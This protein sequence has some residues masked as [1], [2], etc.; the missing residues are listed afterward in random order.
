MRFGL[1]FGAGLPLAIEA[2]CYYNA[3]EQSSYLLQIWGGF[4][5]VI[6]AFVLFDLDCYVWEKTRVNYMLIFEFNQ[7][8]SLNWRQHLEIVGAVFFIFSLF[9]FLCM[10]NFFPGFTIYFP[11]L[12]L[13]VVGTFLIAPVIVPYWRMRRY[14]IIQLI[15][16]FLSGLSTVHFQDFFFADQMV[17]LTYACGNIS[18]FFCLYKRLWRQPQLCNSS[19]SP[20]LGFFTTL[21]GILRVFQ[22]FRRYSDSLKSF[23]HLVNALKYIF[24]IL[25]QMFLS[26]WRIHPGLKYRVLYTIFAGVNSLFSYTWDI[27]MDWNLLV[28][29]DGRWQFREHRILKQLWPY[30]IAMILNFI[31]RSSFIF[32]C[33]FPNHIQHSSGISFFVTLAE[34]MRRCMWNILRVEHEEIYNRVSSLVCV[35]F[36]LFLFDSNRRI[37]ISL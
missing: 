33:I 3:T 24:N 27:L 21:P 10:R 30:I 25:A 4:F 34:I 11:A 14:L 9:F 7:R 20:L 2:A 1:L 37:L 8:K 22:C 19:H 29:K 12:F 26:L 32:Y 17:S 18:L 16:V 31:V 28:R 15:R 23:P 35:Y 13:G 6:F 5:L 36:Y